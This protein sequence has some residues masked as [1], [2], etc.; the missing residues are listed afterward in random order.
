M[1][2]FYKP[3]KLLPIIKIDR[4]LMGKESKGFFFW[5]KEE[6]AQFLNKIYPTHSRLN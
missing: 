2:L 4:K 1:V 5:E 6:E 3:F